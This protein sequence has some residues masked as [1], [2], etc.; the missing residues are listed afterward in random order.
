MADQNR[1]EDIRRALKWTAEFNSLPEDERFR[2]SCD[3][4]ISRDLI[5]RNEARA[6]SAYRV[7]KQIR[8]LGDEL[9]SDFG[10]MLLHVI[11]AL[12]NKDTG[13]TSAMTGATTGGAVGVGVGVVIAVGIATLDG[14]LPFADAVG[15][16]LGAATIGFG[17]GLLEDS[18]SVGEDNG[19][20]P[21]G[22]G[23][24]G[25]GGDGDDNSSDGGGDDGTIEGGD[26]QGPGNE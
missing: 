21:D 12:E 3:L 1:S 25:D 4:L 14:P 7:N 16:V 8:A 9:K 24:G 26:L 18:Q 2:Q 10:Q 22:E 19:G 11:E 17:I 6:L 20:K 23:D 13:E 15:I 5:N